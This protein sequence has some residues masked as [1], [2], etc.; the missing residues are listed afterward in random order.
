MLKVKLPD[1]LA[2]ECKKCKKANIVSWDAPALSIKG[3]DEVVVPFK[4]HIAKY[5]LDSTKFKLIDYKSTKISGKCSNCGNTTDANLL[6][7]DDGRSFG[8]FT[9]RIEDRYLFQHSAGIVDKAKYIADLKKL[10]FC[11]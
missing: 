10:D 3:Q 8:L 7:D 6:F 4:I 1:F 9:D 11:D 2:S 5:K